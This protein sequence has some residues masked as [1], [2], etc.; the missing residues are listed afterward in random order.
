MENTTN[1][2]RTKEN[3]INVLLFKESTDSTL[4]EEIQLRMSSQ[5]KIIKAVGLQS[6][7]DGVTNQTPMAGHKDP[8]VVR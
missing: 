6:A 8:C 4:V 7:N 5:N 3:V 2:S 1:L